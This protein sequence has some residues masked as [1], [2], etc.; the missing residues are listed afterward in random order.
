MNWK[1][2][3]RR[4]REAGV[5]SHNTIHDYLEFLHDSF[6]ITQVYHFDIS[7]GKVNYRKNKKLYFNDPFIIWL[8]DYWLNSRLNQDFSMLRHDV[9]KSRIVENAVANHLTR[10]TKT[11]VYYYKNSYEID[12]VNR[13]LLAEVKYRKKVVAQDYRNLS[14]IKSKQKKIR[15]Y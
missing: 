6:F 8:A 12:F 14:K 10:L 3:W 15:A 9:L 1:N 2:G 13:S 5:G 11:G 7:Q 4:W